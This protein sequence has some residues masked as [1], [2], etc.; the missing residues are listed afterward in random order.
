M[1]WINST[2][3]NSIEVIL[4]MDFDNPKLMDQISMVAKNS[5]LDV[6]I[7]V[8]AAR[9]PGGSRN[10]GISNASGTW[11]CFWDSDD[12]PDLGN[13]LKLVSEANHKE[14]QMAVGAYQLSKHKE[15]NNPKE[16]QLKQA[17]NELDIYCDPGIWRMAFKRD[18]IGE[19][20]FLEIKMG[21]DQHFVFELLN[22]HPNI[23][24]S[25]IPVYRYVMYEA[26]QLT[27][28]SVAISQLPISMAE[29]IKMY[30]R[31]KSISLLVGIY[32]QS[33]TIF[34][35]TNAKTKFKNLGTIVKFWMQNPEAILKLPYCLL[36]I[37]RH[38]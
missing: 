1:S 19:G 23:F 21:E 27:R 35:R 14:F 3:D 28:N 11:I 24:Y 4:V 10:I 9:N 5:P 6:Q 20:R 30:Q 37:L 36:Q 25:T 13:M 16:F 29:C 32:K 31:S 33:I 18:F 34:K 38:R 7:S 2:V 8:S 12:Y 22:K 26:A 17:R 15:L